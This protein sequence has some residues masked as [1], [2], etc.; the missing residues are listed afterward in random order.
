M[1]VSKFCKYIINIDI[2]DLGVK[3]GAIFEWD[4]MDNCF[5]TRSVPWYLSPLISRSEMRRKIF[6]PLRKEN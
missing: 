3:K 6:E 5:M 1:K 2:P 4:D